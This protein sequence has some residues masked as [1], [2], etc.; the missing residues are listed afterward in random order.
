MQ[1]RIRTYRVQYANATLPA[2]TFGAAQAIV[3]KQD[4]KGTVQGLC[5]LHKWNVVTGSGECLA[6][7]N[8]RFEA[9]NINPI[10]MLPM[11]S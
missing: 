7:S 6:C 9:H 4:G 2:A 3:A 5:T 8:A 1:A 11:P 10:T